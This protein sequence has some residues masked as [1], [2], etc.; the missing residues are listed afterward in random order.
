[1]TRSAK[2]KATSPEERQKWVP[3]REEQHDGL[4][5]MARDLMRARSHKAER[6]TENT[7]IRVAVDLVLQHPELLV[8]DTEADLRAHALDRLTQLLAREQQ[9]LDHGEGQ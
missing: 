3:L 5:T 4:S 7:I 8:G 1:M 9:L 2:N 6:I